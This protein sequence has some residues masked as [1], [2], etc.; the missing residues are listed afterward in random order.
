MAQAKNC[1]LLSPKAALRRHAEAQLTAVYRRAFDARLP[2]LPPTLIAW[3]GDDGAL[4][5]AA[6][7]RWRAETF[8][9]QRY[10]DRPLAEC[11]PANEGNQ[12]LRL[13]EVCH[14]AAWSQGAATPF[15]H[16]IV[17]TCLQA[18]ADWA[19]F[20]ATRPLRR[21]LR[22]LGVPFQPLVAATADRVADAGDWGRYYEYEPW[23]CAVGRDA[24]DVG[25]MQ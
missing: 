18:G 10:L 25:V 21:L 14:L 2:A 17:S 12:P 15:V 3:Q 19:L 24:L 1:I 5:A 11:L 4:A 6:G 9:L 20:T 7:L 8:F 16:G 23:V 22:G 13:V